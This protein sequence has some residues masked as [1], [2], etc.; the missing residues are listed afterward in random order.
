L[1][2]LLIKDCWSAIRDKSEVLSTANYHPLYFIDNY[3]SYFGLPLMPQ[4]NIDTAPSTELL[5]VSPCFGNID[6]NMIFSLRYHLYNE[7]KLENVG[8]WAEKLMRFCEVRYHS[9][10]KRAKNKCVTNAA[11]KLHVL[12]LVCFFL[13]Y[14][15]AVSD[16]RFF[17]IA[18]KLMDL[19]W[20]LNRRTILNMLIKQKGEI[21]AALFQFRIILIKEYMINQL[22]EG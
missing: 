4:V 16:L 10:K 19:K 5:G 7:A 22:Q 13:D 8:A 6:D 2:N 17:N 12:H 21:D 20:V 3:L 11:A 18:L 9:L 14:S 15:V 1:D